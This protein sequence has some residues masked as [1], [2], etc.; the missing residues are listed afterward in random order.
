MIQNLIR[1]LLPL[2]TALWCGS[3]TAVAQTPV[4]LDPQQP[5]EQ[6]I[7]DALSR[8]TLDEK[9]ALCHAQSKFSTPG[10]PRL[11]IPELRYSEDR[12]VSAPRWSGTRGNMPVGTTTA[13]RPFPP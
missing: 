6:R 11:G 2:L 13:A 8:M 4:Y 7:E 1:P 10:V 3:W 9:V 5:L 12:T